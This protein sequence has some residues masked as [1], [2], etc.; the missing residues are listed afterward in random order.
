MT[1]TPDD[2]AARQLR[3][4]W[5]IPA[6]VTYLN[7]GAFGSSPR[8]VRESRYQWL[9]R[10][11]SQPTDFYE[12]QLEEGLSCVAGRLGRLVGCAGEDLVLVDNATAAMNIVAASTR[13]A[14]GDEVLLTNHEYGAVKRL[15]GQV[16][17][18]AGGTLVIRD[19]PWPIGAADDLVAAIF[20]GVNPRTRLIVVSHVTSP[21]ALVLPV[22][23]I[24]REARRRGIAICVDGPHALCM[25]PIDLRALD[26]DY[27]AVSC[28][29]WLSGPF[30]TGFLY[31]HPRVQAAVRP[32][33]T[34]WGAPPAGARGNWRDEFIWLGTRDPSAYMSLTAAIDFLESHG[35][36]K[37]RQTTHEMARYA[38]ERLTAAFGG[39][40]VAPED[41]AWYG[42]MAA[43]EL[44][45]G[46][47]RGLHEALWHNHKVEVPIVDWNERR[48]VRVSCYL[49]TQRADVDRLIDALTVE[50]P[51]F[52]G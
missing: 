13:L 5:N 18:R 49:Y 33:V 28:H 32:V 38:R 29:K 15:W 26:C 44:P 35:L 11:E 6:D 8:P 46:D 30:G 4:L 16:C 9:E 52:S 2:A 19:L 40:A 17:E 27:Y 23:Q 3:G 45:P 22:E 37:F 48:F 34:S 39:P 7:H 1:T 50:L 42:S 24:C 14:P 41:I 12:R 43:V 25:R 20:A 51:K 31:A 21:T 36:D 47:C 10:L